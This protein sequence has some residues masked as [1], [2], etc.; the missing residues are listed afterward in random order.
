MNSHKHNN[1]RLELERGAEQGRAGTP[2]GKPKG[3]THKGAAGWA[4]SDARGR[5][6]A[7]AGWGLWEIFLLLFL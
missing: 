6:Q 2:E 4:G 1:K 3:D 5:A 7:Q